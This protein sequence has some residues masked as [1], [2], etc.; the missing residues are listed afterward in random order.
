MAKQ[1]KSSSPARELRPYVLAHLGREARNA[2][3][4][5]EEIMRCRLHPQ[6]YGRLMPEWFEHNE[7]I[8]IQKFVYI[9]QVVQTLRKLR[10]L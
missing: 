9:E 7:K 10:C 8:L 4:L 6:K 3:E 5:H 1:K 2:A